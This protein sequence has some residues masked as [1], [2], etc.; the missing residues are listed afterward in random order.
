M[1]TH[2]TEDN[3]KDYNDDEYL[4]SQVR[5]KRISRQFSRKK[6]REFP[7]PITILG[8]VEDQPLL[9]MPW[10][11]KRHYTSDGRLILFEEKVRHHEYFK[12]QRSDGHLIL[13]LVQLNDIQENDN[14][15]NEKE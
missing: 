4:S 12:A 9:H 2:K 7:P 3:M 10:V 1:C 11:L 8:H 13:Q 5:C 6:T 15:I 14:N